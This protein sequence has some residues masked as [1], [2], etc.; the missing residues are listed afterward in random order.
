MKLIQNGRFDKERAFYG[1]ENI[2]IV[3]SKIDGEADGESAFKECKNIE[4]EG[5]YFNLRYPFWHTHGIKISDCEMTPLC[6]AALWYSSDIS[7]NDSKLLGIKALREC[8]GVRIENSEISSAEFGWF[9]SGVEI[10]NS[11]AESDYFMLRARGLRFEN[12]RLD[13]KYS[14]Q[15]AEDVVIDNCVLNTKD[16]L[17]HAKR[18]TVRNSIVSGEYLG[19]YSEDVTFENCIIKGTQPLCYAKGLRL[20][21][22][23]MHEADLA[24]EKSSLE[25]D[26]TT[27]ILSIKNPESGYIIAPSI[28][29]IISDYPTDCKVW[30]AKDV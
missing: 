30:L 21:N 19:W 27:N 28:S 9:S 10:I 17:W 14:F 15:Y 18:C 3:A 5:C 29:E 12:S 22:C 16:S 7:V 1:E 11:R 23:E 13:G 24:F 8:K 26:I 20:R 2:R 6:R 4:A 25:A